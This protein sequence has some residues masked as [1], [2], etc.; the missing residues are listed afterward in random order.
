MSKN[1]QHQFLLYKPPCLGST[2]KE[3]F[4]AYLDPHGVIEREGPSTE[5]GKGKAVH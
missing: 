1:F 5:T 4:H 2:H 3:K